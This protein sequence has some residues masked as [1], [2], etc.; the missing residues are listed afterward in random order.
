MNESWS[1]LSLSP[2]SCALTLARLA[3]RLRAESARGSRAWR[4][5]VACVIRESSRT[6]S[7]TPDVVS[8]AVKPRPRLFVP[9]SSTATSRGSRRIDSEISPF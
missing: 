2:S 8:S 4:T 7:R 6:T 3:F 1:C 9:M 5:M